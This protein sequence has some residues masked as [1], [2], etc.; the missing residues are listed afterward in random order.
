MDEESTLFMGWS[1]KARET[2]EDMRQKDQVIRNKV[3]KELEQL[4]NSGTMSRFDAFLKD[5]SIVVDKNILYD[6]QQYIEIAQR[7]EKI[8]MS[9]AIPHDEKIKRLEV[10]LNIKGNNLSKKL[11]SAIEE[12]YR[13]TQV[14]D[15]GAVIESK[16]EN[17]MAYGMSGEELSKEFKVDSPKL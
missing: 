10:L 6:M 12:K 11:I 4:N 9:I 17:E 15:R 2:L 14:I 5:F 3:N 1:I 13:P 8:D 7:F 16:L